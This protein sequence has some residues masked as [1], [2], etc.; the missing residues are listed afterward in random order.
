MGYKTQLW[1]GK[2]ILRSSRSVRKYNIMRTYAFSYYVH[3]IMDWFNSSP[4]GQ[5]GRNF[6]DDIFRCIFVNDFFFILI[7]ISL[8]FVPNGS[9]DNNL[10]L[11]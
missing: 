8:K 7:K 6:T 4:P 9:I 1:G 3:G 2:D 10:A 5:N 11:V